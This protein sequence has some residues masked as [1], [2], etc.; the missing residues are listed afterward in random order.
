MGRLL[1]ELALE[2]GAQ[3]VLELGFAHGTSTA[4][5]AAALEEKG[6][7]HLT[8][9]DRPKALERHPNVEEVLE[10]LGLRPWVTPV[11][12]SSYNWTLM[13]LLEQNTPDAD[14]QPYVDLCFIDGAH[15][16]DADGFAFL[17]VDRL[18]RPGGWI[19]FDDISWTFATSPSLRESLEVAAMPEEERIEQQVR[20]V[21]DLLVR[22]TPGY[23]V[24]LLGNLALAFKGEP[25]APEFQHLP[26]IASAFLREAAR[27]PVGARN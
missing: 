19:V 23:Q 26:A 2:P 10:E 9:I 18:L 22:T 12:A 7:G 27:S 15:R 5:L 21:V 11:V 20:K 8:T 1:Y 6:S 17:L 14:T 3:E 4:Y 24:R 13:R 16:W 25:D